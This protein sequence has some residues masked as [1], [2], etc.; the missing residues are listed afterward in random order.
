MG[1]CIVQ[2]KIR[3]ALICPSL[4]EA[5]TAK[6]PTTVPVPVMSPVDDAICSPGGSPVAPKVSGPPFASLACSCRVTGCPA[7]LS[8]LPG[9]VNTGAKFPT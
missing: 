4:T 3:W 5:A 2:V 1:A 6:E 8:R 9:F 7:V